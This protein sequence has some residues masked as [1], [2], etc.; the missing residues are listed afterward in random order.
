V[1][2]LGGKWSA[3]AAQL[4]VKYYKDAGGRYKGPKPT[5]NTNRLSRWSAEKWGY[6]GGKRGGRYL[7]ERVRRRL[8]SGEARRTN[9]AKRACTRKG[10]QWCKQ[11]RDVARKASRIRR[12]LKF[13]RPSLHTE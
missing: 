5:A 8:S 9:A 12:S 7:P 1:A 6:V 13:R 11:P 4:A 10:Q 3:R 2:K